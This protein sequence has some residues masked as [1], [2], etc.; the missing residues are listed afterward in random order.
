MGKRVLKICCGDWTHASRD[1]RELYVYKEMGADVAVIAKGKGESCISFRGAQYPVY[2]LSTRPL[3]ERAPKCVNR[4][5]SIFVWAHNIR[6]LNKD[7]LSCHD[8]FALF[9]GWLS[10]I[11]K[12][13]KAELIYDSHEFELGRNA[14]RNILQTL[15][16]KKMEGFLI[17]RCAYTIVVNDSIAYEVKGIYKLEETPVVVRSIPEYWGIDEAICE[18]RRMEIL[19]KFAQSGIN[20]SFIVMYHGGI[21]RGRGIEKLIKAVSK[22]D[23]IV[24]VILGDADN[25][26]RD[27]LK[28]M[29]DVDKMSNRVVFHDAVPYEELWQ[30]VGAVDVGAIPTENVAKSYYYSLPN[31]FFEC[32]QSLTPIIASDIPEMR[33]LINE[34]EIGLTFDP[35]DTEG[36]YQSIERMMNDETFY[37]Q[38]KKNLNRAK[39]ELCWENE[40]IKLEV[41]FREKILDRSERLYRGLK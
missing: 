7:A 26:Y 13:Q 28:R 17:K 23:R 2:R 5:V 38:C 37:R 27:S 40:K 33:H 16:I 24:L 32:I 18:K 35:G 41:A 39:Q 31:K 1:Y 15:L 6:N 29:I 10:N 4:M 25:D 3:G 21:V 22:D 8:L 9:I 34:Y 30:Y 19:D 11:G 14:K 20:S 36:I 12:K